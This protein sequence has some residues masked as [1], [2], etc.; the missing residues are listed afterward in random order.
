MFSVDGRPAGSDDRW[1]AVNTELADFLRSRRAALTPDD[2]GLP[3]VADG[4]RVKGL[5][6][7]EV[8]LVAGVSPTTTPDWSRVARG[9]SPSRCC[10]RWP[11]RYASTT[12]NAGTS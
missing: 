10:T 3:W 5:R 2:V 8:A 11:R 12:W 6:R 1:V 4:R 7:S 9:T